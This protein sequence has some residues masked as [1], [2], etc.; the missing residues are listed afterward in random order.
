MEESPTNHG[1]TDHKD[2]CGE[3]QSQI[4]LSLPVCLTFVIKKSVDLVSIAFV[5]HSSTLGLSAAGLAT[6]TANVTGRSMIDGFSG[7]I[8]TLC[9]QQFGAGELKQ[10]C[11]TLQ[12]G[13]LI[14]LILI[15][16]PV[17]LL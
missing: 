1:A 13:M 14:Q 15:C 11:L 9:C 2:V 6:V 4:R 8:S 17:S 3:F 12:R 10:M 5:G 7:A 16:L